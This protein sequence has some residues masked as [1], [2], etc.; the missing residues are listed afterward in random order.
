MGWVLDMLRVIRGFFMA[1][2][3]QIV[4]FAAVLAVALARPQNPKDATIL[5]YDFDNIGV[6]GYKFA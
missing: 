3:L 4:V 6:D 5:K 1:F 2:V